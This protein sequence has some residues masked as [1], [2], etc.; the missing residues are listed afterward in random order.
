MWMTLVD[1]GV[2]NGTPAMMT[3][4][5]PAAATPWR[6]AI[7]LALATISSKLA[8]SRVRTAWAPHNRPS[9]RAVLSDGV[10]TSKGT[11]GRSRATRRA[12]DP[13]AVKL[14]IADALT[15]PTIVLADW[16]MASAVVGSGSVRVKWTRSAWLGSASTLVAIRF[17]IATASHG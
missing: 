1:P 9:R 8:I 14:T 17:I 10:S 13:E 2:P 3:M 15:V 4:R 12:V 11:A 16:A 5:W 6:N 7:L